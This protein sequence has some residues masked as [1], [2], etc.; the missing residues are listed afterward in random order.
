MKK[1]IV[2]GCGLC[3][4][5]IARKCAEAGFKVSIIERRDHIAGNLFDYHDEHGILIQKYGPHTFHTNKKEIFDYISKFSEWEEYNLTCGAVIN[6]ICT[7]TPF[8][9]KTI[10]DFY[11]TKEAENIKEHISNYYKEKKTATVLELLNHDDPVIKGYASFLFKHDYSLY[12]A[13][14]WGIAPEKVDPS[15]LKRVP[16]RFDYKVGYFDDKYQFMPKESFLNFFTRLIDHPHIEV[17]LNTDAKEHVKIIENKIFYDRKELKNPLVYTG[18]IDELF[19]Y[20]AG[21]LPYRSLRFEFVYENIDS[22]QDMPVVAYPQVPDFTRITEYKKLPV[23]NCKGTT[24][25]VEYPLQYVPN[26]ESE[27]YYPLLT[28]ESISNYQKYNELSKQI[29]NLYLCGRLANYKYYNMDQAIEVALRLSKELIE[30]E[31]IST[32]N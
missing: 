26:S 14:Q 29:P 11:S 12:T 13:K 22:K 4:G 18:P 21:V 30:K 3:G 7:P 20:E 8:N 16:L 1:I 9:F 31:N 23:Q 6:N 19:N 27:P 24:Y 17:F 5:V 28:A 2:V 15:I 10:D 25:A 32:I